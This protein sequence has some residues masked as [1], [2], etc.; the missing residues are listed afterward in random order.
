MQVTVRY[1]NESDYDAW[2][3]LWAG[4]CEFSANNLSAE[5]TASTWQRMLD[6]T[7]T[8]YFGLVAER[9]GA[10]IGIANCI[11]HHITWEIEPRCYLNDLFIDPAARRSGAGSAILAHL[12]DLCVQKGWERLYWLSHEDNAVAQ[13]LYEQ[14]APRLPYHY[15]SVPPERKA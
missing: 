4:Y 7:N 9:D 11:V 2:R 12:R 8:S 5:V 10:V 1:I 3:R 14:I 13:G 6:E 15:Y